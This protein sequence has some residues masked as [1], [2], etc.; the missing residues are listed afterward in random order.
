[1]RTPP[2]WTEFPRYPV[3][4]GTAVLA[5][6]VTLAWW[7]K[8]NISPLFETVMIRR[9]E[10]W[11][12]LTNIFPH[13][14]ILHLLFN[15]YWIWV[16]GTI[17]EQVFGH[18]RT[19]ALIVL[20]AIGSGSIEFAF[21]RGGVGL[22]GVGYGLFGLLWILSTRDDRFRDVVD[23]RTV[24]LFVGWFIFC[25]VT[26]VMNIYPV[27]NLAHAAGAVLG[28]L[29]AFAIVAPSRRLVFSAAIVGILLVGLWGSTLGRPRVNLAATAGYEEGKLGYDALLAGRDKEAARWLGD[30]V[31][32]QPKLPVYWFDLGIAQQRLGNKQAARDAYARAHDLEPNNGQYSEAVHSLQ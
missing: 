12:L 32:Y 2:K 4:A 30:A 18:L 27:A 6:G 13:T 19:A 8:V 25:V 5:I 22:S 31:I 17:V 24:Q 3:T 26:T 1:V 16:F 29:T 20:F 7:A 28:A 23:H 10:L 14:D 15:L 11:R 21:A 9:G